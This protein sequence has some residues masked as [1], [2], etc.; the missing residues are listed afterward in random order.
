MQALGPTGKGLIYEIEQR[1]GE[2]VHV[3]PA[4]IH[5]VLN[6]GFCAKLAVET[7][8][9][10]NFHLYFRALNVGQNKY[11]GNLN[12]KEYMNLGEIVMKMIR[13]LAM[14]LGWEAELPKIE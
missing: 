4:S 12:A 8:R 2:A 11:F 5:M 9:P 6:R 3:P 7:V 13:G 10:E 1:H 14:A